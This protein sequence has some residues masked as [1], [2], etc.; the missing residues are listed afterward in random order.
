MLGAASVGYPLVLSGSG[1]MPN[2][3]TG[4]HV[5]YAI[6]HQLPPFVEHMR[7]SVLLFW[8]TSMPECDNLVTEPN[9]CSGSRGNNES[10]A[11]DT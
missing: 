2:L 8:R 3:E 9:T 7:N 6:R 10:R 5:L 1:A 4:P 11:S